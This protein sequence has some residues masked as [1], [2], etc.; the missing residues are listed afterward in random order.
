ML[1]HEYLIVYECCFEGCDIFR[2][3]NNAQNNRGIGIGISGYK[4]NYS[5]FV[6][7]CQ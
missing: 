4:G 6:P 1:A 2:I 7:Q 3:T 5:K